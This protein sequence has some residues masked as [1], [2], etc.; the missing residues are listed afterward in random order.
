[1]FGVGSK[2]APHARARGAKCIFLAKRF[3]CFN[4]DNMKNTQDTGQRMVEANKPTNVEN[5]NLFQLP[6]MW[7]YIPKLVPSYK[8]FEQANETLHRISKSNVDAALKKIDLESDS[9]QSI[10]AKLARRNGKESPLCSTMAQDALF[11]GIDTT[12]ST[13]TFALYHLA[14]NP[15][16]QEI[17]YKEVCDTIGSK[18]ESITES[19]LNKMRYLKACLQESQ[20]LLP[21]IAG[22]SRVAQNDCV[23]SRYQIPKGTKLIY[24]F[25]VASNNSE[26]FVNPEMFLPERWLRSN[27]IAKL[28]HPFSSIPFGH[29]PRS[30]IGRRFAVVEIY[31][32]IIKLL[33][34]YRV[35]YHGEEPVDTITNMVSVPNREVLIKFIKRQHT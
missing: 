17:L 11:T 25:Q 2:F 24:F 7:H 33:Q 26:N 3:Y 28:A 27:P 22:T 13:S 35:E 15:E 20:R 16:K 14:T 31:C 6:R 19:K 32:L 18:D 4:K 10:L 21:V 8:R 1:M 5:R 30:C 34:R 12:G 23:I 29:G 9:E